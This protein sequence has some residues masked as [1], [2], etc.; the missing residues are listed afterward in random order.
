[1]LSTAAAVAPP[2]P[3]P[4][5]A[6]TARPVPADSAAADAELLLYLSEFEDARGEWIDPAEL[7]PVPRD[8]GDEDDGR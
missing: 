1:M 5:P 8:S 2:A 4:P 6:A 7:P 3:G